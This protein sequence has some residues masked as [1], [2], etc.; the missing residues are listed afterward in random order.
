MHLENV[1]ERHAS[2]GIILLAVFAALLP[3]SCCGHGS[4]PGARPVPPADD[5][6]ATNGDASVPLAVEPGEG[7]ADATATPG[8]DALRPAEAVVT[9]VPDIPEGP[10]PGESQCTVALHPPVAGRA[11]RYVAEGA[12]ITLALDDVLATARERSE[13]ELVEFLEARPAG[14]GPI[15]LNEAALAG[16]RVP[17][18]VA[19][20][21]DEGKAAV[22]GDGTGGDAESIVRETWDWVGCGGGCRQAGRQYRLQVPGDVFFRTTDLFEDSF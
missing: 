4:C 1:R 9:T 19:A 14:E 11:V 6:A 16:N 5:A 21:L 13:T 7:P 20:L 8:D 3:A 10:C 2:A 12:T 17:Y 22:R 18:V 15:P